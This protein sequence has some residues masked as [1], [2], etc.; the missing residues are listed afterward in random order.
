MSQK[1]RKYPKSSIQESKSPAG[2]LA[3]PVHVLAEVVHFFAEIP[4]IMTLDCLF[5]ND[6]ERQYIWRKSFLLAA[7]LPK[8]KSMQQY[9]FFD[10]VLYQSDEELIWASEVGLLATQVS[11]IRLSNA[12]ID[13]RKIYGDL[14]QYTNVL[15]YACSKIALHSVARILLHRHDV[16]RYIKEK[17]QGGKTV[18]MIAAETGKVKLIKRLVE[19]G[20]DVNEEDHRGNTCLSLA[21]R[22]GKLDMVKTLIGMGADINIQN[23]YG[24]SPLMWSIEY[25]RNKIAIYLLNKGA[26]IFMESKYGYNALKSAYRN[27][28]SRMIAL[29]KTKGATL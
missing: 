21:S 23:C 22:A 8:S 19:R 3:L 2:F 24:Y 25:D 7:S 28:N 16:G 26:D 1:I 29:L 5:A 6:P 15:A 9:L 13:V 11:D 10:Q 27:E 18:L 4:D 17:A 20:A 14:E 12:M